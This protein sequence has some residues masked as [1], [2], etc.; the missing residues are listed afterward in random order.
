MRPAQS[1]TPFLPAICIGLLAATAAA[2]ET[3]Q[4]IPDPGF[5]PESPHSEAFI[6]QLD[7]TTLAVLPSMVRRPDRTA[8][9][10]ASQEQMVAS[11]ND[12]GIITAL[13]K[14][15]RIDRGPLR[16]ASQWEIFEYGL[17][18]ISE[19]LERNDTGTEFI[20][21]V[22]FLVPTGQDVFGIE[23]YIV[24]KDGN[25][26]FSFLMNSHHEIFVSAQLRAENS[27]EAAR[28]EMIS[29]ATRLVVKALQRQIELASNEPS[30]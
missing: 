12:A 8:H 10:F 6:D 2:H 25:N 15:K 16:W 4:T 22:E 28:T 21:V 18:D 26:A 5:R 19:A 30:P 24:D 9:S 20:M 3:G 27:T 1:R 23:C 14:P 11:L 13:A 17:L 7:A 29:D